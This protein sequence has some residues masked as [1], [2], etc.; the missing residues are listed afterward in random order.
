MNVSFSILTVTV[1][2]DNDFL[3]TDNFSG[4]LFAQ[5]KTTLP[6]QPFYA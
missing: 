5:K 3:A 6:R 4:P 1:C 2:K